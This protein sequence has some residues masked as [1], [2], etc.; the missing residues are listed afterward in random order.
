MFRQLSSNR[1]PL[2]PSFL[3]EK[4]LLIAVLENSQNMKSCPGA[5][6]A[7]NEPKPTPSIAT[8]MSFVAPVWHA[9][10]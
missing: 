2:S 10:L 5:A 1:K 7:A 4:W 6:D 3:F 9:S 8:V